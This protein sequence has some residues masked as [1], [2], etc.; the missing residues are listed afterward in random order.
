MRLITFFLFVKICVNTLSKKLAQNFQFVRYESCVWE[1]KWI[2]N[3]KQYGSL[4]PVEFCNVVNRPDERRN[5]MDV[6]EGIKKMMTYNSTYLPDTLRNREI[7]SRFV[8]EQVNRDGTVVTQERLIEPLAQLLRYYGLCMGQHEDL[9]NRNYLVMESI[10]EY[11]TTI[12]QK[13]YID[14]GASTWTSGGGGLSSKLFFETYKA[15]GLAF[16]RA[17]L[18]EINRTTPKDLFD[19]VPGEFFSAYQ[20]FNIPVEIGIG[21]A[22]NPLE[23]LKK[24]ARKRDFVVVKID[25]DTPSIENALVDQLMQDTTLIDE[26]FYEHHVRI[27]TMMQLGWGEAVAGELEDTYKLH[28]ALR[29]KGVRSHGWP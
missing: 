26:F 11:P 13:V 4:G 9:L 5:A 12:R 3:V 19:Q 29:K 21:N 22:K 25:I 23:I 10:V 1:K 18:W 27:P 16:D 24:I 6:I 15:R 28:I 20:Y 14:L 2:N 8:Y 17:L 7:F